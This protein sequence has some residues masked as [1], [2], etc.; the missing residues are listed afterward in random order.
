MKIL[1]SQLKELLPDLKVSAKDA[2]DVF[3]MLGY[4]CDGFS[5]V[6]Y[7][8]AEDYLISLEVRQ[9]RPDCLSILGLAKELSVYYDIKLSPFSYKKYTS[10]NKN[11]A[12]N[13]RDKNC[14]K[15][16]LAVEISNVSNKT[17]PPWLVDFLSLY[18]INSINSVVDISN[19]ILLLTG[20]PS[21]IFD[22][23]K[24]AGDLIW[25]LNNNKYESIKTL[26]GTIVPLNENSL[27]VE[28]KDKPL[29]L[30]GLVGGQDARVAV[31][32]KNIIIETAVYDNTLIRKNSKDLNIVT[33][34]SKRLEKELD[35]NNID[36][37]L[38]II[39]SLI[40]DN[41]GGN[42]TSLRYDFYENKQLYPAINFDPHSPGQIA[43]VEIP[44]DT[45]KRI[46]TSLGCSIT[47][48]NKEWIVTPPSGRLDLKIPED[49]IE[50]VI[51]FY[52][53]YKIPSNKIP[54]V[55]IIQDI[56]PLSIKLE[57]KARDVLSFNGY[58]EVM[59]WPLVELG[60]NEKSN[61][62]EWGSIKTENAVNEDYPEL[63]QTVFTG[64]YKQLLLY[65]KNNIDDAQLFEIGKVFGFQDNTYSENKVVGILLGVE[66]KYININ[67]LKNSLEVLL[68]TLG[69]N[70]LTYTKASFV[71]AVANVFS[72]WDVRVT[73]KV[74]GI[75]YKVAERAFVGNLYYA[76]ISLT[77]VVRMLQMDNTSV[78]EIKQ[79]LIKLDANILLAVDDNVDDLL[80]KL[81]ELIGEHLWNI[82]I[83]DQYPTNEG[84]IKYTLRVTYRGLS[85]EEAKSLDSKILAPYAYVPQQVKL[86]N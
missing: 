64:L 23:D 39:V 56:T 6:T 80:L 49:L 3:T 53:F 74:V 83:V 7:K 65:Q 60:K 10:G 85:D 71:P 32:T 51:R 28:D 42:V 29:A 78:Y 86:T 33:E 66:S 70:Q 62:K 52:G 58:D 37:V 24:I 26:D 47:E 84:R 13:V 22:K 5:A 81:S 21:H 57:E 8:G 16:I 41:C 30:A 9:N 43:G 48:N 63:R 35:P 14:V 15:R 1:Y 61:Y 50:E 11:I 44:L 4:L 55:R 12:I 25:R 17:S 34:A 46:L 31:D 20:Q 79:K 77:D 69:L 73:G 68:R 75:I 38:D 40:I 82:E 72:C 18:E 36:S 54:E 2:A 59:S 76:E 67:T 19:Y 27:I 45:V